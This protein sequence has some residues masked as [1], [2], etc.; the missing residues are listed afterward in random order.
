MPCVVPVPVRYRSTSWDFIAVLTSACQHPLISI[1]TEA[2]VAV[3]SISVPT[4]SEDGDVDALAP[5]AAGGVRPDFELA[6]DDAPSRGG[7]RLPG[8]PSARLI[9]PPHTSAW[10]FPSGAF[11]APARP[12]VS[13]PE[14]VSRCGAARP[15]VPVGG[16]RRTAR[17]ARVVTLR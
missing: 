3:F 6:P 9:A 16:A 12:A 8:G 4:E 13:S 11:Q 10:A 7:G 17:C 5:P 1:V 15:R 14:D 2:V